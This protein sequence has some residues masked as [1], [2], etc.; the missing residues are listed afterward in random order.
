MSNKGEKHEITII[1]DLGQVVNIEFEDDIFDEICNEIHKSIETGGI[2]S[3]DACYDVSMEDASGNYISS[4]NGK[5]I[6]G[7]SI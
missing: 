2:L 3:L 6:V 7:Y 1:L 4:L 5:K